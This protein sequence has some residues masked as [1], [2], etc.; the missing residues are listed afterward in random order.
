MPQK[1]DKRYKNYKKYLIFKVIKDPYHE[2]KNKMAL[3]TLREALFKKDVKGT[4]SY[5]AFSSHHLNSDLSSDC[6]PTSARVEKRHIIYDKDGLPVKR[7]K[8]TRRLNPS[9]SS[10]SVP[11]SRLKKSASDRNLHMD[12]LTP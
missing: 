11:C 9:C 12:T 5:R 7:A 10:E 3:P 8:D 4:E 2:W 6:G 1:K